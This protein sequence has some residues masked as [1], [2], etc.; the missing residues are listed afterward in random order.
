MT[1]SRDPTCVTR[2]PSPVT[3]H[4]SPVTRHPSLL[5]PEKDACLMAASPMDDTLLAALLV[6]RA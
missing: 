6:K 3:R 1:I 2:H 5:I 4:P